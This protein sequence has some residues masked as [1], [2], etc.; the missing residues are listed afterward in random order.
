MTTLPYRA[1]CYCS[2]GELIS[3]QFADSYL[4]Q[5][6]LVFCR[7]SAELAG[8]YRPIIGTAVSFAYTRDN[9]YVARIPRRFRV[10]SSFADPFTRTTTLQIG[11]RLSLLKNTG[12]EPFTNSGSKGIR[13]ASV[14]R[15]F[16]SAVALSIS[17]ASVA[18]T[19]LSRLGIQAASGIP[20]AN[21]YMTDSFSVESGYVDTLAKLLESE[22]YVGYLNENE[23]LVI[24]SL[25]QTGT[26]LGP[27]LNRDNIFR[28]LPG[29]SR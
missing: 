29:G 11:C 3:A 25:L 28:L 27:V 5:A 18:G 6:G 10:L 12:E 19:I 13:P 16:D 20:L 8:I 1:K 17:A 21:V 7:G 2:L 15:A 14:S 24:R 4:Q 22:C 9:N 23:Q 26:S